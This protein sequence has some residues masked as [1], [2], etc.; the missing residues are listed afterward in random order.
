MIMAAKPLGGKPSKINS[1]GVGGST[2]KHLI[3]VS[4]YS[5]D[6]NQQILS[7]PDFVMRKTGNIS[8]HAVGTEVGGLISNTTPNVIL[9]SP[10][11]RLSELP[12]PSSSSRVSLR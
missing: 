8:S 11:G 1:A 10:A 7:N 2:N 5:N 4:H 9:P 12:M 3:Q 6:R